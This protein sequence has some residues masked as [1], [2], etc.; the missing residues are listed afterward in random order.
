MRDNKFA[1]A[2]VE[3]ENAQYAC[4][5]CIWSSCASC[6]ATLARFFDS[7]AL[8]AV[9]RCC[10]TFG[11]TRIYVSDEDKVNGSRGHS[12]TTTTHIHCY[13]DTPSSGAKGELL[14][15]RKAG[16]LLKK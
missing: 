13:V 11:D 10:V 16:C 1:A 9:C 8:Y 15:Q 5:S 7:S 4:F 14:A 6:R 2:D 12:Y 3:V